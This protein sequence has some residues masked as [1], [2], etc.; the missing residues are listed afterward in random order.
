MLMNEL[1]AEI[2]NLFESVEMKECINSEYD[3]LHIL[4]KTNIIKGARIDIHKK[5]ELLKK[6][7]ESTG[8]S[9]DL[10]INRLKSNI[11]EYKRAIGHI[12]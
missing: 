9:E 12:Y 10:E 3:S 4:T 7:Y 8:K 5:L 11:N 2:I 1:K 6:L